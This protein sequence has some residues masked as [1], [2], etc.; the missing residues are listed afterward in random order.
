MNGHGEYTLQ[1]LVA[2]ISAARE[3]NRNRTLFGA[4]KDAARQ[5]DLDAFEPDLIAAAVAVGLDIREI[6]TTLRS[7]RGGGG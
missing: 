3:G 2:R 7:V 4:L 5:S 1:C 6:E